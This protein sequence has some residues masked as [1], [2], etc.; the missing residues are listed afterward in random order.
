MGTFTRWRT[1][2]GQLAI[3]AWK[4]ASKLTVKAKRGPEIR[5]ADIRG[6]YPPERG[7]SAVQTGL[8]AGET[9]LV[10][11]SSCHWAANRNKDEKYAV[12]GGANT[13]AAAR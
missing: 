6:T 1:E 12:L 13:H 9:R 8:R 7:D 2:S 3:R 11:R 10:R 4:L 5:G